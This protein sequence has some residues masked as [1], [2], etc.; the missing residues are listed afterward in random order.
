MLSMFSAAGHL[1]ERDGHLITGMEPKIET[2][3]G[4]VGRDGARQILAHVSGF[5]HRQIRIE[6]VYVAVG[7]CPG[8]EA[9]RAGG[10]RR[11][12]KARQE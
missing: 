6:N 2:E 11:D 9:L 8:H 12:Q 5:E 4:L 10:C 7:A 1:L 3:R